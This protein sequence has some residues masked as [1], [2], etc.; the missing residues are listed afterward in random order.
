AGRLHSSAHPWHRVPRYLHLEPQPR[1]EW[2]REPRRYLQRHIPGSLKPECGLHPSANAPD[3]RFPQLWN[4]PAALR[5]GQVARRQL[6]GLVCAADRGL[7]RWYD[8][9]HHIRS[10]AYGYWR[11]IDLWLDY[12]CEIG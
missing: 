8:R 5:P 7:G 1:H 3:S 6:L 10:A 4:V 2:W 11:A 9:Q 12:S